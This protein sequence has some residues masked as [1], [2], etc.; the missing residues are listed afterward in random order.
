MEEGLFRRLVVSFEQIAETLGDMCVIQKRRLDRDYPI[1]REP[2]E[3]VVSRIKTEE[4]L[5]KERQGAS[6]E[7]ITEWFGGFEDQEFI[8][9]REKAFLEEQRL[10]SAKSAAAGTNEPS[11]KAPRNKTR[12][13]GKR[14]AVKQDD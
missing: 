6:D 11:S 7:P 14:P 4:D 9:E 2:R 10:A 13:V 8:G 3:A 5:A 1:R 12:A